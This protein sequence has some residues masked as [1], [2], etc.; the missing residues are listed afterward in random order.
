MDNADE[1]G[2]ALVEA[3]AEAIESGDTER[4]LALAREAQE[5]VGSGLSDLGSFEEAPVSLS[6]VRSDRTNCAGDWTPRD[7]LVAMLRQVD[8]GERKPVDLI[9]VAVTPSEEVSGGLD[10]YYLRAGP[11]DN[12][13][14]CGFLDQIKAQMMGWLP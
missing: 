5:L 6:E 1:R 13:R 12:P 14:C 11:S 9:I 2:V 3:L 10:Y 8:R 4:Q 7:A